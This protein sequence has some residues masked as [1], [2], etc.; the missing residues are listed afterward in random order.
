MFNIETIIKNELEKYKSDIQ[1]I[2][3]LKNI[4]CVTIF[5]NSEEDYNNLNFELSNNIKIDKMSS[6]NLYYLKDGI[7]TIYGKLNF[8]KLRKYII[9]INNKIYRYSVI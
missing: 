4:D 2:T 9:I 8:I 7:Y 6:G 5:A 3:D 1:K